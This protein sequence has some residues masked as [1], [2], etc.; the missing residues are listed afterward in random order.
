MVLIC[1]I[2]GSKKFDRTLTQNGGMIPVQ[3]IVASRE[4]ARNSQNGNHGLSGT[5]PGQE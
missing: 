2:L 1:C 3:W 4:S 5:G